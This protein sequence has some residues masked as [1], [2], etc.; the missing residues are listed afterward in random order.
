VLASR[1]MGADEYITK[2]EAA[3]LLCVTTRQ[4]L[5]YVDDGLLTKFANSSGHVRYCRR[6]VE[7][8]RRRRDQFVPVREA[9]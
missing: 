2:E 4:I 6:Q 1:P 3:G 7:D 9:C 5:R 8:F